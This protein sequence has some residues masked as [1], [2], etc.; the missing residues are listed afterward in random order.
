[1]IKNK[2]LFSLSW[3]VLKIHWRKK[4]KTVYVQT[5]NDV[6]IQGRNNE[7]TYPNPNAQAKLSSRYLALIAKK[8]EKQKRN[9]MNAERK[10]ICIVGLIWK[11]RPSVI[12][13][14]FFSDVIQLKTNLGGTFEA[15]SPS[16]DQNRTE[17]WKM[18][19]L[20]VWIVELHHGNPYLLQYGGAWEAGLLWPHPLFGRLGTW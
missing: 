15:S 5:K 4:T 7:W 13:S 17:N 3:N 1:M 2:G 6:H 19:A 18:F 10:R 20:F 9:H 12:H 11:E 8:M 16:Q 14:V